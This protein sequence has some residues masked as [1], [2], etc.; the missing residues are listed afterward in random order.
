MLNEEEI[1][2][3]IIGNIILERSLL[4][5]QNKEEITLDDFLSKIK[6]RY[7]DIYSRKHHQKQAQRLD[8]ILIKANALYWASEDQEKDAIFALKQAINEIKK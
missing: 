5:Q 4:F 7:I 2:R 8:K 3:M 1:K 6:E